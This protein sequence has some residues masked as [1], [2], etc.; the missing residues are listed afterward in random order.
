MCGLALAVG[1]EAQ[2]SRPEIQK[3]L[4]YYRQPDGRMKYKEFCDIMENGEWFCE[5]MFLHKFTV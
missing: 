3:V 4:E 1:K 5:Y 2:L